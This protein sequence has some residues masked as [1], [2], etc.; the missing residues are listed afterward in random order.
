[1]KRTKKLASL[2]LALVM[3]LA[4]AACGG[5]GSD[6]P[7]QSNGGGD[8][9]AQSD[10]AA[11]SGTGL[12]I[13]IIS[14]TGIDDGS[15]NQNCYE[16]IQAFLADH[17]DCTVTDVKEPDY[18]ELVPTVERMAGDFDVFVLPGFNFAACGDVA[19]ANPDTRFLVVD[20]TITDAEGNAVT[21]DNVYTMTFSEQESG[22][23]AGVAAA[24]TTKSGKVAV[25]NGMAYPSNVNY[26]F[27]F[28][29]GVNYA[30]KHYGT[31]AECV[32]LPSY[33]GVDVRGV[34]VGGNYI[35]DFGDEATGK[36]VGEA[37]IAEGCDVLFVAAG[38]AG[39]GTF[40]AAKEADGVWLIGCDVDQYKDGAKGSGNIMLTSALKVMDINVQRQLEAIYDGTFKGQDAFLA[41]DTDS[42][43]YVSAEGHQQLSPEALKALE[44]CYGL[45]KS[46]T[47]VPAAN[48]NELTPDN[49][50]GL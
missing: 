41:A 46:G 12:K 29:S 16:G 23:F 21:L 11:P 42:T 47:I 8:A 38:N 9:P 2:F 10:A 26:Q 3:L 1:M 6:A 30:N 48:F 32:E 15:F 18:A 24:M 36:V 20:S 49:F 5:G 19:A 39:N 35:G 4:L 27:G 31:T 34:D 50:P 17:S 44:E 13:C 37:L 7:A 45:V 22:F 33:A 14:S 43:G 25:V 28:M 40:T